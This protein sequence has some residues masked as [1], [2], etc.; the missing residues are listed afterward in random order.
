MNFWGT[1]DMAGNVKEW[2]W[3]AANP[4]M[5]YALGGAWNEPAYMYNTPD[6]RSPFDRSPELGFRCVKYPSPPSDIVMAPVSSPSRDYNKETPVADQVFEIYRS[7]YSYDKTPLNATVQSEP[8]SEEGWTKEKV[9]F[10]AAYGKDRVAAYLF[11]PKKFPPPYQT[12]VFF[13]GSGVITKSSSER[14]D[15]VQ[16]HDFIV[17]SGRALMYPIYRGTYERRDDL[18]SDWPNKTNSYRD[19]VICWSKDLGRSID[20]LETRHEID[21]GKIAFYGLSWGA[22]LGAILPAVENR[23]KTGVLVAGGFYQ[24][25]AL[26]EAD[27]INFAPRVKIPIL[28]LNGRYDCFVPME[29][30]QNP[31]FRLLGTAI[32]HK[33]HTLCESGHVPPLREIYKETLTW[34]DRYLGPV[35]TR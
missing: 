35:R 9:S 32:D 14:F 16:M 24:Q 28:M 29:T 18:N 34:L 19:H 1:Y 13:P 20:Y 2:C 7:Q 22:A 33:F 21:R 4:D 8:D 26:P 10:D 6:A 12:V 5:R 11:L 25:R 31:M 27:Q 17:K 15:D 3:N 30:S 23:F